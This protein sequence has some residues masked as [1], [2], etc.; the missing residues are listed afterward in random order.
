LEAQALVEQKAKPSAAAASG[1]GSLSRTLWLVLYVLIWYVA[2]AVCN[3]SARKILTLYEPI[4]LWLSFV[5]IA[6]TVVILRVYLFQVKKTP[7]PPIPSQDAR[8]VIYKLAFTYTV[9]FVF[10]N[11]GYLA[12]N[13][14]LAETLRSAE[15]L[16]SVFFAKLM[17]KDEPISTLTMLTLVPIVAGGVLSSGGDASFNMLGFVFVCISN[18]C[19][20]L[21]SVF[22][23]H[24]K[25]LYTGNAIQVFYELCKVGA[26]GVFFLA[27]SFEILI[28]V[29]GDEE[30]M[31]FALLP[32][33]VAP[34]SRLATFDFLRILLVNGAT[35]AAYNQMS[36][37]VLSMVAMVT[38]AVGNSLRRVFTIVASVY[39]FGNPISNQNALG[40]VLAVGGV[41]A[42]S[43]SKARDEA[44]A[45]KALQ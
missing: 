29:V 7:P 2:S 40:I 17:L 31:K 43:I 21:R 37:L 3:T 8:D 4:P 19:F 14:S 30:Q 1:S 38:H 42:Y 12:V 10:V 6:I 24:L 28:L 18:I 34:G 26:V 32:M 35:Y 9:G 45:S 25:P 16:F 13:V 22:M 5:Q 44:K 15:P 33:L 20:A 41:I 27:I 36:F 23:K 39:I 11:S